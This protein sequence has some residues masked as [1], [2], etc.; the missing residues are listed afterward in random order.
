MSMKSLLRRRRWRR[1]EHRSSRGHDDKRSLRS[2]MSEG[3]KLTAQ[4]FTSDVMMQQVLRCL[5]QMGEEA[6]N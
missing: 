1:G 6:C 5:A 4:T 3:L 2:T